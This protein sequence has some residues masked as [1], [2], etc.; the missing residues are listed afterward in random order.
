MAENLIGSLGDAFDWTVSP[1][2]NVIA[3]MEE[4]QTARQCLTVAAL[5]SK[6]EPNAILSALHIQVDPLR[7]MTAP[8]EISLQHLRVRWEGTSRE[9]ADQVHRAFDQ[10]IAFSGHRNAKWLERVGTVEATLAKEAQSADLVVI[11]RPHNL[12]ANDAFHAAIFD[13]GKLVLFVPEPAARRYEFNRHVA[14]AWKPRPQAR[15]AVQ[16]SMRWLRSASRVTVIGVDEPESSHDMAE[17]IGILGG[18]GIVADIRHIKSSSGEHVA[19]RILRETEE[20]G[21]NVLVMGAYRFG[22][23]VEWV[24]G[25][26]TRGI[27]S[28]AELPILMM[29]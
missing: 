10:W 20:I 21:A 3:V 29:H 12:D 11:A 1:H 22:M 17:V 7:I 19:E 25:G 27:V 18:N 15:R 2:L 5:A 6:I 13:T 8:E 9:R 14:I 26:V 4:A 23:I 28:K 16:Q 24:F